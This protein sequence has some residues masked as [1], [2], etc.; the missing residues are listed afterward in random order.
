MPEGTMTTTATTTTPALT[1]APAT[2][3]P[4]VRSAEEILSEE[5]TRCREIQTLCRGFDISPDEF[6]TSGKTIE[7]T[8]TAVLM[9]IEKRGAPIKSGM[10]GDV[11]VTRDAEDK[12]RAA[13]V[14]GMILRSGARPDKPA[15]GARSFQGM[16][17]RDLAVDCLARSGISGAH[18]MGNDELFKRSLTPDSGFS[19]I[20][21]AIVSTAM[22]TAY[23]AA[24]TTYQSWTARGTAKDFK[25]TKV[26]Q[27]SEAG[28]LKEIAQNGEF[29]FDE[30]SDAHMATRQLLTFGKQ[31]GFTRQAFIN[32]DLDVLTKL[33]AAYV[34]GARRG[35]N[36]AV[37]A[38]LNANPIMGDANRLFSTGHKNLGAAGEPGTET[39][40]EARSAMR[41]QTNLRGEER[42]NIAPK[43][44]LSPTALEVANRKMLVSLSDPSAVN[45]GVANIFQNSMEL[46]VDAELDSEGGANANYFAA[47]PFDIDT[48]EVSYLNGND[49][50]TLESKTGFDFLGLQYRIFIDYGITLVDWRGLFMTPEK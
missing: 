41:R 36:K 20:T 6:I 40:A 37:Y 28:E 19:A 23:N 43:F 47:S 30:I 25:P 32:D 9:A 22:G 49:M 4:A 10:G 35:I 39:Y 18:R 33:P 50:P 38:I 5:R 16:T 24:P 17:L 26:M 1:L 15:E 27:I 44:V 8:R 2:P 34:R 7:E 29:T 42:L 31:F 48:I 45:A 21:S 14:D 3:A 13:A 11:T 46:I 12:H